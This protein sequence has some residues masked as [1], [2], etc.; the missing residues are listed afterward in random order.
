[1]ATNI[2][3]FQPSDREVG[4]PEAALELTESYSQLEEHSASSFFSMSSRF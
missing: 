3:G 2:S 1:M 4:L